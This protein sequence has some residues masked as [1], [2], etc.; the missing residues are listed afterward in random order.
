MK[1][2]WINEEN[3][4]MWRYSFF[5]FKETKNKSIGFF[6]NRF[7]ALLISVLKRL[8][9]QTLDLSSVRLLYMILSSKNFSFVKYLIKRAVNLLDLDVMIFVRKCLFMMHL[10]KFSLEQVQIRDSSNL[11]LCKRIKETANDIFTLFLQN[12]KI[13]V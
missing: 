5:F 12:T 2:H 1:A 11:F 8:D 3:F 4:I 13:L 7:C 10:T 9:V 6:K